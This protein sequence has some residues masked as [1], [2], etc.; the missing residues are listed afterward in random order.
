MD[1]AAAVEHGG[2]EAAQEGALV[3]VQLAREAACQHRFQRGIELGALLGIVE[4]PPERL[5]AAPG[6]AVADHVHAFEQLGEHVAAL[7]FIVD[8]ALAELAVEALE[9]VAHAAEVFGEVVG[10]ADDLA[11]AFQRALAIERHHAALAD[12]RDLRIDA[13]AFVAQRRQARI[14]VGF[15]LRGQLRELLDHQRQPAFGGGH[16]ALLEAVGKADRLQR[17]G[18]QLVLLLVGAFGQAPLQP[19]LGQPMGDVGLG[20]PRQFARQLFAVELIQRA[21]Q[22]LMQGRGRQGALAI[23]Q[24]ALQ[25]ADDLRGI[26]GGQQLPLGLFAQ[27]A[28]TGD[29][30]AMLH[31]RPG[32]RRQAAHAASAGNGTARVR[33]RGA[34]WLPGAWLT[35]AMARGISACRPLR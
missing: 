21:L 14:G 8:D 20:G 13:V 29:A 5:E 2:G 18:G 34:G 16:A 17:L 30:L 11:R 31:C 19:A 10:Q 24:Q 27:G 25:Q 35:H 3:A 32:T 28:I 23:H 4:Q 12:P 22:P 26:G 1:L 6:V 7:A 33:R 9:V 15:G